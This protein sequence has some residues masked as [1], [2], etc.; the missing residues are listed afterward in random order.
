M[1]FLAGIPATSTVLDALNHVQAA[2]DQTIHQVGLAR[3]EYVG[4]EETAIA[5]ATTLVR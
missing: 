5:V 4:K 1:N 2:A 3:M